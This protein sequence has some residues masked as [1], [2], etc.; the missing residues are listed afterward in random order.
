M[1][2]KKSSKSRRI[3]QSEID[4][5]DTQLL[6][7][8]VKSPEDPTSNIQADDVGGRNI[9][10]LDTEPSLPAPSKPKGDGKCQHIKTAAK[11]QKLKQG[12]SR[13]KEWN[14]CQGCLAAK[15]KAEKLALR[16]NESS[17][18]PPE[19][20]VEAEFTLET[21]TPSSLWLCLTCC[22]INCGRDT[23]SHALAH[24]QDKK[25]NHPL[26]INLGSMECWCY[27]CDRDIV[28]GV[29]K[30]QVIREYQ[31]TIEEI[32]RNK[33]SKMRAASAAL[34]VA[35]KGTKGAKG[36]NKS[37]P[38]S[39]TSR[40]VIATA[41]K[42]KV[43]TPGL[44]N[45]GNTCFFNSVVQVLAESK[46]LRSIL[47]D[48]EK[49]KLV[50][51][52]SLAAGTDVG[53]G[54]LATNFKMLMNTMRKQRGGT[55]APREL[56]TQIG[57]KWKMFR[58]YQQQDS[59]ELMR[60]L[61]D[62]IKQEE[63]EMIKRLLSEQTAEGA[64][65][66]DQEP[67]STS[68]S[69]KGPEMSCAPN[70]DQEYIP[71]IDSCFSGK[72]IS[73]IVCDTCK[74]CSYAPEDFFDL[75]LSVRKPVQQT[76][77][78]IGTSRKTRPAQSKQISAPEQTSTST[79][80]PLTND[81]GLIPESERPSEAHMRHI[82][83]VLRNTGSFDS[84]ALSIVRSLN[85]FTGVDILDGENK[86][87]CEN[88]Y[89]LIR[90]SKKNEDGHGQPDNQECDHKEESTEE[91]GINEDHGI[92]DD[93]PDVITS[94]KGE[95]E[96]E[97]G[98]RS[99]SRNDDQDKETNI[100]TE[101]VD[102]EERADGNVED[103]EPD[104]IRV[105][106]DKAL[107]DGT[108]DSTDRAPD[109]DKQGQEVSEKNGLQDNKLDS[110][111]P[112]GSEKEEHGSGSEQDPDSMD[113]DEM[114]DDIAKTDRL[115]NTVQ[116]KAVRDKAPAK[117]QQAEPE[118]ILRKAFKR[119]LISEL[120]PTLVLH[121]KRFE[122]SGRLGQMR[123]IE[124]HVEI[125]EELDMSPY[126]MS[127]SEIEDESDEHQHQEGDS[128]SKKY[129]LYGAVVHMGT[130]S[131]GHYI[132]YVLSSKVS[133]SEASVTIDV[134]AEKKEKTKRKI[135]ETMK[136]QQEQ[137]KND[138][139]MLASL[140]TPSTQVSQDAKD[141]H[142]TQVIQDN[143]ITQDVQDSQ[144]GEK[145]KDI[146]ADEDLKNNTATTSTGSIEDTKDMKD[147]QDTNIQDAHGT[148]GTESSQDSHDIQ[149]AQNIN[150]VDTRD[151]QSETVETHDEKEATSVVSDTRQW[152]A[153]SDSS[154]RLASIQEVLGSRAYLL[155]YERY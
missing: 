66:G 153:C 5:V 111:T 8:L 90:A 114:D 4:S 6:D 147:T 40:T 17:E 2:K 3:D 31:N 138:K 83:S 91:A 29:N 33:Q 47:F 25:D 137:L 145:T 126:F 99:T 123:K 113:E 112:K 120:P 101:T 36:S 46:S 52:R 75:S 20:K 38:A 142:V 67:S 49:E 68:V 44:N 50:L 141:S 98:Q 74:K 97:A 146:K 76:S 19:T 109:T 130:L 85:Q 26:A 62:G 71:F 154:V 70:K 148:L 140:D 51:P 107:P 41:P 115:G 100:H 155:F 139:D 143:Q 134:I 80:T 129:K 132:N 60:H 56:F 63:K 106:D 24:N 59:H 12:L 15:R 48:D 84:E 58:G 1:G 105:D 53:L 7:F 43:F 110:I 35:T 96:S 104:S 69:E 108:L 27:L 125:P 37:A 64:K 116:R 45:L 21:L 73:V 11:P 94:E 28:P 150:G 89:K 61:F 103:R 95:M 124:D 10:A 72:L 118:F 88:C 16:Q 128:P 119:Y 22:E 34:A 144:E 93:T 30:H 127:K 18:V 87:A 78:S 65:E 133:T 151:V 86:F 14:Q 79:D 117:G 77:P 149:D 82:E 23:R 122:R 39:T 135:K 55:V 32:Y 81:T 136:E 13:Q 102:V 57:K 42:A 131:G 152:I 121:L 54:P 9:S 92:Q